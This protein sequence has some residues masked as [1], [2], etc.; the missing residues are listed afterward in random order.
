MGTVPTMGELPGFIEQ[1]LWTSM[2]LIE[3]QDMG[4][5]LMVQLVT[6][7]QL[8]INSSNFRPPDKPGNYIQ[9]N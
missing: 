7:R 3:R 5:C 9:I 4:F 2:Y 6:I 1:H 8:A